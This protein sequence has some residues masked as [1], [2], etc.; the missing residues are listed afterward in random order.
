MTENC[1]TCKHSVFDEKYGEYKC[2]KLER[3]IYILLDSSECRFYKKRY[4][5]K[6]ESKTQADSDGELME[7]FDYYL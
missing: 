2:K 6:E 4:E 1:K 3:R 7:S 5:K